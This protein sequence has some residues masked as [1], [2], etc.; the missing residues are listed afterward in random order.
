MTS[1]DRTIVAQRHWVCATRLRERRRQLGLTQADVA[2]RLAATG[3]AMTNRTLSAMEHGHGLDL[4][5]LPDLAAALNCTITYLIGLT[6]HPDRWEPDA[7]PPRAQAMPA[8][9]LPRTWAMPAAPVAAP[10]QRHNW[11]LGPAPPAWPRPRRPGARYPA[12]RPVP[13]S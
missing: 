11:I 5:R 2:A 3:A 6:E 4:G 13:P 1:S 7:P 8:A 9:P 12:G 10:D